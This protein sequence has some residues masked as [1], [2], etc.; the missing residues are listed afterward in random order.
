[1]KTKKINILWLYDDLL[2]LYGDSGNL[3]IIKHYLKKNQYQ[4][5]IDRKSINDV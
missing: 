4:Y 3:M 1:M 2:D 5:Q